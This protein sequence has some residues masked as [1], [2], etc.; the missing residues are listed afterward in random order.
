MGIAKMLRMICL[1]LLCSITIHASAAA[2]VTINDADTGKYIVSGRVYDAV[3]KQGLP[4]A[5][6]GFN[7]SINTVTNYEGKFSIKLPPKY[8]KK[9]FSILVTLLKYESKKIKV[10]NRR[11][12]LPGDLNVYLKYIGFDMKKVVIIQ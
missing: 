12:K 10:Q 9:N 7:S 11:N 1:N 8:A 2:A 3:S 4:G 6:V 5:S